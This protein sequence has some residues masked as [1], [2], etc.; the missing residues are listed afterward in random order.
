MECRRWSLASGLEGE[1]TYAT[2]YQAPE[3]EPLGV[4][5]AEAAAFLRARF[6]GEAGVVA[7]VGRGEWS[8]AYR[9]RRAGRDYIIRF[10]ALDEDFAKDRLA[11]CYTSRDLPVPPIIELGEAFDGFYAISERV[12]GDYLDELDEPAMRAVL[13]ALLASLDATR[14]A[15][16]SGSTGHGIWGV[17]GNA[18]HPTWRAA[19]LDVVNDR[20]EDRTHGWRE[21]LAS[22]PTGAGPFEEAHRRCQAVV[23]QV[24]EKRHL[25]HSDLLHDDVLVS[26]SRISAVLDWGCSMYGDF[27]YDVA[28]FSFWSPWYAAWRDI[29]FVSEAARHYELIGLEVSRLEERV[30]CYELHIGLSGQAYCAFAGH[31]D[32]L[33]WTAH[34]TLAVADETR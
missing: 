29:D 32:D 28:W 24:P 13:P 19:L 11:A 6:D 25:I 5:D 1:T 3:V 23:D 10:S 17:D 26:G 2:L 22:S 34:R 4:T 8:K 33:E 12:L 18:P 16:V 15:D 31:W 21:R 7:S 20:P 9:F 30:R 27:L 14:L